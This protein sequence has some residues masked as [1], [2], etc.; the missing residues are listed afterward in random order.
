MR[1][2]R[3]YLRIIRVKWVVYFSEKAVSERRGPKMR[4]QEQK[5]WCERDGVRHNRNQASSSSPTAYP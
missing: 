2:L 3:T 4:L 5:K 1:V